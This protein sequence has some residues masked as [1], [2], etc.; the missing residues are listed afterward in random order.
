MAVKSTEFLQCEPLQYKQGQKQRI[1]EIISTEIPITFTY[2]CTKGETLWQGEGQLYAHP[3]KVEELVV[4]HTILDILPCYASA[5]RC[6]IQGEMQDTSGHFSLQLEAEDNDSESLHS[7]L[8]ASISLEKSIEI[9][10]NVL[11]TPGKWDGTG[12]FHRAAL[13]HPVS[14]HTVMAEDIGRHNCVDRLKGYAVLHNLAIHEYFIFITARIT[15]SL[16]LKIR[17]AGL[18]TMVSRSAITSTAYTLA[19]KEACTLAAFCRPEGQR[20]TLF[21]NG[22]QSLQE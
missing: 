21:V 10:Q 18:R 19:Q 22:M 15:S 7:P 5:F 4:G 2:S 11:H 17:R 3:E 20:V 16:F 9:M 12:C 6:H 8:K 14:G 13:F 1:K